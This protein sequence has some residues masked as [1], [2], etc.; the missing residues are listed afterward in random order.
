MRRVAHLM[1]GA[2]VCA[3]VVSPPTS[4]SPPHLISR[5]DDAVHLVDLALQQL[6]EMLPADLDHELVDGVALVAL[7]DVDGHDVAPDGPDPA[8]H[9]ARAHRAG[10]GSAIRTT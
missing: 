9:Q 10:P 2:H 1:D 5:T 3:Y 8:G 4:S 6:D 7:Q